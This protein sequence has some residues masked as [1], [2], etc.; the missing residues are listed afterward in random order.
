MRKGQ[1]VSGFSKGILRNLCRAGLPPADNE[2]YRCAIQKHYTPSLKSLNRTRRERLRGF[3]MR[4]A[5]LLL[6]LS[7]LLF[8]STTALAGNTTSHNTQ[9]TIQGC[10]SGSAHDYQL[11]EH[12]GT[13]HMLMGDNQE[14]SA[15][16]G[17]EVQLAG[18]ADMRRDA[19]T[20]SDEAT[21][22]GMRFFRVERV[23]RAEGT[24][25]K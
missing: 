17:Q 16:V 12:N 21:A 23:A 3:T 8:V 22:H 6:S 10:L 1:E 5:G 7:L 25:Q 15:H 9:Q 19:S 18:K 4:Y 14:L 2:I 24:C 13:A 11:T 20:S